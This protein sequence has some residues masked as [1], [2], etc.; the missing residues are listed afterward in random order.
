MRRRI[1]AA[2]CRFL[3]SAFL[4]CA[5]ASAQE[6]F[7]ENPAPFSS[8][9]GGFPVSAYNGTISVVAWQESSGG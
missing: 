1:F 8:E 9:S 6:L 3:F 7:W 4:F 2:F 5:E